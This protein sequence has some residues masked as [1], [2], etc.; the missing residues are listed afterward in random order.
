MI[1][2]ITVQELL[3]NIRVQ[4]NENT[5]S[6]LVI[7]ENDVMEVLEELIEGIEIFVECSVSVI[8]I[9]DIQNSFNSDAD[10]F[11]LWNFDNWDDNNWRQ[12]D[13]LRSSLDFG[14][15][16][17]SIILSPRSVEKMI[18]NAPNFSSWIGSRVFHLVIGAEILTDEECEARLVTLREWI[19]LSD[20]EV[21]EKATAHQ[22]PSDP[23]YG[24]WLILL[25]RGDLIAR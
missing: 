15:R 8:N 7:V 23:E 22:L 17:G 13:Y 12:L 14:K 1:S 2:D 6:V 10:Y 3:S 20:K 25:G 19:G 18:A 4:P 9:E 16:G 5:W 24:E 11:L 21:I